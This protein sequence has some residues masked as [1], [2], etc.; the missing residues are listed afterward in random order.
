MKEAEREIYEV[1]RN[2]ATAQA[3]SEKK[4]KDMIALQQEYQ[5]M[6]K[7]VSILFD[8][9]ATLAVE[10]QNKIENERQGSD[11][12]SRE[13]A[14][15]IED[16]IEKC[17]NVEFSLENSRIRAQDFEER[18]NQCRKEIQRVTGDAKD[19]YERQRSS[20]TIKENIQSSYEQQV[21]KL[22]QQVQE[23]TTEMETLQLQQE[24]ADQRKGEQARALN[25]HH[26]EVLN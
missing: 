3:I 25:L 4:Q 1:N 24:Y 9:K 19:A 12:Q 14:S 13:Q 15:K 20:E 10:H 5:A 7:Q 18:Y 26:H 22:R 2:L 16:L 8:E 17:R 6:S 21:T 11:N 23:L